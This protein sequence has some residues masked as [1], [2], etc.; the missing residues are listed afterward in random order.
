[1]SVLTSL[2]YSHYYYSRKGKEKNILDKSKIINIL[3]LP[4]SYIKNPQFA[5][6]SYMLT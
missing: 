5:I 4:Y 6:Y 1:M 3:Y 2:Y